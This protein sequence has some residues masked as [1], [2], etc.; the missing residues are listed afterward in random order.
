[1]LLTYFQS[2]V[3]LI[4]VCN[5]FSN[6]LMYG[7]SCSCALSDQLRT[8][9]VLSNCMS[10]VLLNFSCHHC[11]AVTCRFNLFCGYGM[12]VGLFLILFWSLT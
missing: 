12:L 6:D 10:F 5:M 8:S 7:M 3:F 11:F 9:A 4:G 2:S 1:M